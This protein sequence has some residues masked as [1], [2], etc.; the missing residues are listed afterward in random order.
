MDA[1]ACQ[2]QQSDT[3]TSADLLAI[4]FALLNIIPAYMGQ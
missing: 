4:I 2:T 1:D 3:I